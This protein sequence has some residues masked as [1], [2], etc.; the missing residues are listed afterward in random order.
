MRRSLFI[1]STVAVLLLAVLAACDLYS[2]YVLGNREH[3]VSCGELPTRAE[4]EA[5]LRA[6][7]G[8]VER[9]KSVGPEKSISVELAEPCPG[10]ADLVIYHPSRETRREIEAIID[11]ETF[12]GI[13]YR[14]INV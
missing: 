8:V 2:D 11:S 5:I 7:I 9:I 3:G 12:Y 6:H 10:K 4:A 1:L 14:L 13:P